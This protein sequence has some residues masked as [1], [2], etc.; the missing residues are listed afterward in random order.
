MENGHGG[1]VVGSEMSCGVSDIFVE[2][3]VFRKTDRGL[4]VKTRRGRGEKAIVDG[5][6]FE[7]V[8]MDS[9]RHCFVINMFYHCDPDG[10]S[11]YV[12]S[13]EKREKDKFTP[14]VKNISFTN[15]YA[16]NITGTAVFIYGLPENKVSHITMTD[17]Y[18]QFAAKNER[19]TECPAMMCDF[20]TIESLGIFIENGEEITFCD[21]FTKGEH[22]VMGVDSK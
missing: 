17:N 21:N 6:R 18:F 9:V 3:C 14:T 10:K 2:K 11:E 1:V 4:R 8:Q 5:I 7:N 15:I 12:K 19:I 16:E 13:K 20:K 22:V